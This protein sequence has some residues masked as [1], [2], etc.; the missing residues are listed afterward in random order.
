MSAVLPTTAHSG[1][2]DIV[3]STVRAAVYKVDVRACVRER[4]G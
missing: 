1:L 2:L 4:A 3:L